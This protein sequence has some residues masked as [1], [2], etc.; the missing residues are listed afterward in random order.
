M[1]NLFYIKKVGDPIRIFHS[2]CSVFRR[3]FEDFGPNKRKV[4]LST[5]VAESSLTLKDIV[6]VFDFCLTKNIM[7]IMSIDEEKKLHFF[8]K[9]SADRR[10]CT[11]VLPGDLAGLWSS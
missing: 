8:F 10:Y 9:W 5:N 7:V 2:L 11:L 3:I 6:Y 1:L 4:I